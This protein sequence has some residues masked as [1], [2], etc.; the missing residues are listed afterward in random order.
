M[1]MSTTAQWTWLVYMAGDDNLQGAGKD[2]MTKMQSLRTTDDVNILVQFDTESNKTT[3][4]RVE[5]NRL[6]ALQQMPG[7]D[8]GDP[9]VLTAFLKWGMKAFPAK[10]YL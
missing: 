10:R 3:R 7:V 9:K 6:K 1:E 5:K 4:Y 2:D 8:S